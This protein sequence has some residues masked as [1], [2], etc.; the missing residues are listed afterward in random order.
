MV[1]RVLSYFS[2]PKLLELLKAIESA[3][4][5]LKTY[6]SGGGLSSGVVS[7]T[8]SPI[9][10]SAVSSTRLAAS[11]TNAASL[12]KE[13]VDIAY[14]YRNSGPKTRQHVVAF[15]GRYHYSPVLIQIPDSI[16]DKNINLV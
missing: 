14:H 9:M 5:S 10:K 8:S 13:K 16:K 2:D 4:C 1:E 6:N 11:A 7:S 15:E 12:R 3:L